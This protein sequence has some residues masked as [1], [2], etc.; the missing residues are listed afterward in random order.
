MFESSQSILEML[1]L[2]H[3]LNTI[4]PDRKPG[5]LGLEFWEEIKTVLAKKPMLPLGKPCTSARHGLHLT[6]LVRCVQVAWP[7]LH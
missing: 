4:E 7:G 1:L 6:R 2:F 5:L 3:M